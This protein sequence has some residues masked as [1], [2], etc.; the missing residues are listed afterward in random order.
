MG[1][2]RNDPKLIPNAVNEIVRYESPLRAFSRKAH[3]DNDIAGTA[4]PEGARVLV[5][6]ASA[7]RDG[8]QFRDAERF[9][10]RRDNARAHVAFGQGIH[11]CLGAALARLEGRIA[12]ET[13]LTRLKNIRMTPGR[14][15][16]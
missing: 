1:D 14:R 10:V 5:V 16:M 6:Y 2:L 8:R 7:N 13:L 11:F 12:F 4:I 15:E 3:H 9:D